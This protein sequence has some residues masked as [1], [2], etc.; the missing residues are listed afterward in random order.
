MLISL[1]GVHG[2][3][4][5]TTAVY[6]ADEYGFIYRELEVITD[7][8]NMG[9]DK[10]RR[11]LYFFGGFACSYIRAWWLAH[12]TSDRGTEPV[13]VLDNHPILVIPYTKWHVGDGELVD[14][15]V[16]LVKC[17]PKADLLVWLRVDDIDVLQG[18]ILKRN[19]NIVNEELDLE[20]IEA[21]ERA[22]ES[23][24]RDESIASA[25]AKKL[26]EV[27]LS[28]EVDERAEL[29]VK[30]VEQLAKTEAPLQ[31]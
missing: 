30:A 9:L 15:M 14:A 21:V 23:L 8:L 17:L 2:A 27:P 19:R 12:S 28:L 10:L 22:L 1:V 13:V 6:L 3:G 25:V 16:A 20:Y 24:L 4:K 11:Q 18:R 5:T 26:I 31:T 7:V 29:I